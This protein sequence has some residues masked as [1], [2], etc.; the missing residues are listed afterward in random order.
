MGLAVSCVRVIVKEFLSEGVMWEKFIKKEVW[1]LAVL[2]AVAILS[3]INIF[4]NQFIGDDFDFIV[5]WPLIGSFQNV[6]RFFAGYLTPERQEGIYSPL[7]TLIFFFMNHLFGPNPLSYHILSIFVHLFGVW[8][9]YRLIYMLTDSR[10]ISFW[11]GLIFA[12]HP[13]HVESITFMTATVDTIGI[14]FLLFSFY[15]YLKMFK[16]SA[17][18]SL[19][20]VSDALNQ[21]IENRYYW[22]SFGFAILAIFTH[23]L[24][25]SLPVLLFFYDAFFSPDRYRWR[26][27]IKRSLPF[28]GLFIF[29]VFLKWVVLG[30]LSRGGYP[31]NAPYQTF[32]V[33]LKA[34]GLYLWILAFPLILTHNRMISP[35]IFSF[36]EADFDQKLFM[37]QSVFDRQALVALIAIVILIVLGFFAYRRKKPL[38]AFCIGWFFLSLLPVAQIVPSSVFYAERYLYGA[39]FAASCLIAHVFVYSYEKLFSIKRWAAGIF[40]SIFCIW[41]GFCF[42]RTLMRNSDYR[43]DIV[44][45]ERAV[46]VSPSSSM[47]HN[48]LGI[49]YMEQGLFEKAIKSF[50][51]AAALNPSDP[52][53][54]FSM[55]PAYSAVER[56]E[57]GFAALQKAVELEPDYAEAY[58]NLAGMTV[59]LDREQEGL[60]YFS[61]AINSWKRKKM[62]IE[63][64]DAFEAFQLFLLERKGLLPEPDPRMF[65][66]EFVND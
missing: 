4:P 63:A 25:L 38:A 54:Y 29:Y 47:L 27:V 39:S 50:E 48:D 24:A 40:L 10:K 12:V 36:D 34:W 8:I 61:R 37:A 28:V 31:F 13:I 66:G 15:F 5:N 65:L 55:E 16:G 17:A 11:G 44:Y 49:T 64:A 59:F 2:A 18:L 3:F 57:E 1:V 35:G 45:Y 56:Y 42:V 23:E 33:V 14:V 43:D 6:P 9:V 32:L 62:I 19:N 51:R 52:E 7:R 22:L 41:I 53:I 46:L 58:F 20:R 21:E 60:E 26:R 30:E